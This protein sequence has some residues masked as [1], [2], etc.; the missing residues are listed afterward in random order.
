MKENIIVL[1]LIASASLTF[2]QESKANT[3]NVVLSNHIS[4]EE[5]QILASN[6][7]SKYTYGYDRRDHKGNKKEVNKEK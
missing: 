4:I 5:S 3:W 1:G 6:T 7:Q 2:F